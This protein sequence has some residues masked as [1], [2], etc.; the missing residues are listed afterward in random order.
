MKKRILRVVEGGGP[1]DGDAG[2]ERGAAF[3]EAEW[4]PITGC[5]FGDFRVSEGVTPEGPS[6]DGKRSEDGFICL[7]LTRGGPKFYDNRPVTPPRP[8]YTTTS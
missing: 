4:S 7:S 1:D 5:K 8:E 3:A 6:I 2:D